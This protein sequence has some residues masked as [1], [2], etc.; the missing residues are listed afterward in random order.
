MLSRGTWWMQQHTELTSSPWCHHHVACCSASWLNPAFLRFFSSSI[1]LH[2]ILSWTQSGSTGAV[3]PWG[4]VGGQGQLFW[5]LLSSVS[6]KPSP[7]ATRHH[8]R[9]PS[10]AGH[11]KHR[12]T[13]HLSQI[14]SNSVSE[15]CHPV[16]WRWQKKPPVGPSWSILASVRNEVLV[17]HAKA[18]V[19]GA[20]FELMTDLKRK[21][22]ALPFWSAILQIH[23]NGTA[24]V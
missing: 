20:V 3:V 11:D 22:A 12:F 9:N 18:F 14:Q 13:A 1:E 4:P 8:H 5:D 7:L 19:C 23:F 21:N 16:T 24:V 6:S 15:V 10:S 2:H 17:Y